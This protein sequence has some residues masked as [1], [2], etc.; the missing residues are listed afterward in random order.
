MKKERKKTVIWETMFLIPT[1]KQN[2]YNAYV[3]SNVCSKKQIEIAKAKCTAFLNEF[4]QSRWCKQL[5]NVAKFFN[6]LNSNLN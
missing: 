4:G 3:N 1:S 5:H 6:D 2:T